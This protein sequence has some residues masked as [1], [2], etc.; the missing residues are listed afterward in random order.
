MRRL[1]KSAAA[2][3]VQG[4]RLIAAIERKSTQEVFDIGADLYEA[5]VHCH[6]RYMPAI[7]DMYR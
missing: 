2:L 6:T 7:R 4:E 5:C 3:I 1:V